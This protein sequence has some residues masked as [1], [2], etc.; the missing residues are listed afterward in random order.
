M[1]DGLRMPPD[2]MRELAAYVTEI[3]VERSRRL[4]DEPA[5]DGEFQQE[6]TARLMEEPPESG[7]PPREVIDRAVRDV[8][9]TT[10]RH[11]H[12]KA[13]GFVPSAPTWPGVLA[14]YLVTG[15]NVNAATWLS[16]SGPS[17]LEAVVIDWF[18]RW[19]GYPETAG[20]VLTSGGSAA[21]LDAFVAA[22]DA[23]GH[24]ARGTVY[25]SDQSHSAQ[26]RAARVIGIRPDRVRVL[27]TDADFRLSVDALA[28]AVEADRDAGCTPVAVC[29]DAGSTSTGTVDPLDAIADYCEAHGIWLH[30]DAAYGG[31]AAVTEPGARLLRGIE[32]ADSIGLDPHKWFFQPYDTGC[33][34][35]RDATALE[36]AFAIHHDVLQDSVWGANHPNQADRGLQL[37]RRD[38]AL[39]IWMSVQIFG[40]AAFRAAVRQGIERAERAARYVAESPVLELMTPASLGILCFRVNPGEGAGDEREIHRLNRQVLARVFWEDRAFLSSTLLHRRFAL[41]MCVINHTTTWDD[42][43]ETLETIERFGR[44]ARAAS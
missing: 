25:M 23:A 41:R 43:R 27:P 37:S 4:P 42:V 36:R 11:D 26:K 28:S 31:F 44:E 7:R 20:G 3:L 14:D 32:R 13:F 16:A 33:L 22:R 35:V 30:V 5:W 1:T 2:L 9:S 10:M 38:R 21:A 12:P 39:K 29:A 40:M 24:P 34:L 8:L 15:F 18:R 6:L 19:L 17:Q